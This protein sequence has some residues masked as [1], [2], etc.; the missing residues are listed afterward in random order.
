VPRGEV[1]Q[2]LTWHV[3]SARDLP[4]VLAWRLGQVLATARRDQARQILADDDGVRYAAWLASRGNTPGP[5]ARA[6]IDAAR[7]ELTVIQRRHA[8]GEEPPR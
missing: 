8:V 3:A 5:A 2:L 7:A 6:A 4:G 1:I